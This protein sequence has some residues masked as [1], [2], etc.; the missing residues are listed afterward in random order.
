MRIFNRRRK[1][2]KPFSEKISRRVSRI[3]TNDLTVWLDQ[4]V[5][6]LGRLTSV[7]NRSPDKTSAGDLLT[8]AEAVHAVANEINK[9]ITPLV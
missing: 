9:R 8:T 3:P 4:A 1:W 6:E 2:D 7:Y 5:Y